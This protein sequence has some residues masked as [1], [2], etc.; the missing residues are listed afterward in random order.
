MDFRQRRQK[1]RRQNQYRF[2][3]DI[4]QTFASGGVVLG[5]GWV[6]VHPLWWVK[7]PQQITIRTEGL[8]TEARVRE[9]LTL[10]QPQPLWQLSPTALTQKLQ[11]QA[12][13]AQVRVWRQGFPSRV[14]VWVQER[15]PVAVL[16]PADQGFLD[17]EGNQLSAEYAPT[18]RQLKRYPQLRVTGWHPTQ[19]SLWPQVYR[20]VMASPVRVTGIDWEN[21][22][23]IRLHTELGLIRLGG[24]LEQLPDQLAALDRL[25]NLPRQVPLNRIA[26]IDLSDPQAPLVELRREQVKPSVNPVTN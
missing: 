19:K 18:L 6:L 9:L 12:I 2:W 26:A 24:N 22:G 1:M 7:E 20:A 11:Q 21:P 8:L 13:V 3:L 4:W 15:N 5:L 10:E 23:D 17:P 25:R 16:V 14:V